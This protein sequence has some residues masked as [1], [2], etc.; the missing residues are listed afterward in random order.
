[1]ISA[2]SRGISFTNS[3]K[4]DQTGKPACASR[5]LRTWMDAQRAGIW[6]MQTHDWT[7]SAPSRVD[8]EQERPECGG[9]GSGDITTVT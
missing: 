8:A 3:T 6:V 7:R 2:A 5:A 4:H 9:P 1:M